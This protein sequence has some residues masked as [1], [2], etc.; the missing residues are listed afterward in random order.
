MFKKLRG[1]YDTFNQTLQEGR[2]GR[3]NNTVAS[4]L[5]G[6][7]K[8]KLP[9]GGKLDIASKIPLLGML[10]KSRLV[11]TTLVAAVSVQSLIGGAIA[12]GVAGASFF[13][14]EYFRCRK[15]R[16]QV[17]TEVNFAGQTVRGRRKDLHKLHGAQEKIIQLTGIFNGAA[18]PPTPAELEAVI[19]P[20]R[21]HQDRV[22]VLQAGGF[23]AGA[24]HYEF[25]VPNVKKAAPKPAETPLKEAWENKRDDD[26]L[27]SLV[28]LERALREGTVG[29]RPKRKTEIPPPAPSQ[30]RV[31]MQ[32]LG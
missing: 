14:L 28:E 16:E 3:G 5:W 9:A 12:V 13:T 29:K 31:E 21:E 1:I 7:V 18:K 30:S 11:W 20:V 23:G 10:V 26:P 2:Y 8:G 4:D 17:I 24:H 27:S 32:F 25:S 22:L 19:A 15:A 6:E